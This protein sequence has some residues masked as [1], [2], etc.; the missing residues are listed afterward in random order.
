MYRPFHPPL[1]FNFPKNRQGNQNRYCKAR[2]FHSFPWLHYIKE[3]DVVLC[4]TCVKQNEKRN[5]KSATKKQQAFLSIEFSN[6]K[7][8]LDKFRSYEEFHYRNID[9]TF[10]YIPPQC[11]NVRAMAND[12][13]K[14]SMELNRKYLIKVVECLQYLGRQGIGMPVN[15]EERS[16]FIQLLRLRSK[17]FLFLIKQLE[18][19]TNKYIS[20]DIQNQTP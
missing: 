10:E 6:W 14:N 20:H 1:D 9:E 2:W 5:P 18:K 19:K 8:A 17:D 13:A 15:D 4:L 11:R 3:C 12:Q 16:N 7:D